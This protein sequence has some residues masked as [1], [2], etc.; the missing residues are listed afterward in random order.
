MPLQWEW[1]FRG[2][3]KYFSKIAFFITID[4]FP[5]IIF[6]SQY[7]NEALARLNIAVWDMLGKEF[8]NVKVSL[9]ILYVFC[10][11]F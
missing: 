2:A 10:P 11:K 3:R 1:G 7:K 5:Y 9:I 4:V 8:P 6:I